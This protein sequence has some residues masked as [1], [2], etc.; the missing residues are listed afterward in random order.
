MFNTELKKKKSQLFYGT[1]GKP[2]LYLAGLGRA[3]S[4]VGAIIIAK[5]I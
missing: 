1:L 5:K 4:E 3:L 2:S